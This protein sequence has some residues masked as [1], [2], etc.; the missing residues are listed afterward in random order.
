LAATSPAEVVGQFA[1]RLRRAL[2]RAQGGK[3]ITF[4]DTA[5]GVWDRTYRGEPDRGGLVGKMTARAHAQKLR[6][7][8]IYAILDESDAI[9]P[10]HVLAAEACWRYS[11]GTVEHVFSTLRGDNVQDKLLDA[12]RE[13][14]PRGLTGKAQADLFGRNLSAGRLKMGREG[15]EQAGLARTEM[16]QPGLE[17]GRPAI[18]SYAVP[19]K[20]TNQHESTDDIAA[21]SPELIRDNSLLSRSNESCEDEA[22]VEQH[23]EADGAIADGHKMN[24][25]FQTTEDL[26]GNPQPT[27]R[28]I[29][30]EE[31]A[32]AGPWQ[33]KVWPSEEF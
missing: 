18:I 8:V 33:R 2:D 26:N 6:L 13:A 24:G 29:T 1:K 5:K 3:T 20:R 27:G 23:A 10:A 12:L 28:K 11:V 9:E 7:A 14:Y 15:L 32:A 31:M 22:A 21:D 17:G 25:D 19:A 30:L 16:E 4:S